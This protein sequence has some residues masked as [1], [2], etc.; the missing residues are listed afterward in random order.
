MMSSDVVN[1]VDPTTGATARVSP[2]VG[3]NC[4]SFRPVLN[5][6]PV[7]LLWSEADFDSGHAR[8]T[9]SGIPI[10]FPFPGRLSGSALRFGDREVPLVI[11]PKQ[12]CAIHGFVHNRP[13]RVLESRPASVTGEFHAATDDAELLKLW[14]ADFRIRVCYELNAG[15]LES[16]LTVD[17]PGNSPLPFG[18]G[19]HGYFRVPLSDDPAGRDQCRV[20]APV[21]TFWELQK[22]F[23]TGKTLPADGAKDLAAGIPY[24]QTQLDDVFTGLD[25]QGGK[26]ICH[27][28]DPTNRRRMVLEFD[29]SYRECVAFD[30]PHREAICLEPY[31]CAPDAYKLTERGIDAGLKILQPGEKFQARVTMR[32][33][34]FG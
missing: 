19:T 34:E 28:E 6:E 10:L 22:M 32:L 30:P 25:S 18:L 15:G 24:G 8:S 21:R 26:I 2:C 27:V 23:P 7:E 9:R 5:G 17:N 1:L 11:D 13:W 14:P 29:D 3:F 4:F 16:T 20:Y 31:T 12:G 33:E